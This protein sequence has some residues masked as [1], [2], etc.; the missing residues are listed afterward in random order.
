[1][2]YLKFLSL[3][4]FSFLIAT[5][6]FAQQTAIVKGKVVDK[7]KKPIELAT[8]SIQDL[9]KGVVTDAGGNYRMQVSSGRNITI[10][11]SFLGY[12]TERI[13]VNLKAGEEKT[14]NI[15]LI[16][17]STTIEGPVVED[18]QIRTSTLARID[19]K[20]AVSIPSI[21]GN[22][23]SLIKTMPGVASGNELSSQYSVR[24]GNFDENLVYVNDIEIYRPFLVRSG[25]QEGL[26]F[27][28]SDLVSS[29]LFSAGGFDA[30]YGDKM[31][32]VLD[33][34]Y[35]KPLQFAGSASASLL[36]ASAH[37]E[38][39]SNNSKITY[40][41]GVRYKSNQY[42]LKAM[43]TKGEYKPSFTDVQTYISW[44]PKPDIEVSF[45]GN[46]AL[47][48][49]KVVPQDRETAF[50]TIN[51]AYKFKVYFEGQEVDRFENY[52]SAMSFSWKPQ[53]NINLKLIGSAFSSAESETY[54]ILGQYWI[55]RLDSNIGS[56][57]YADIVEAVGV[58][59]YLNHARNFLDAN[60]Y[61]LE[62]RAS[63]ILNNSFWQWGVKYQHEF[64]DD[65]LNEWVLIDSAGYSLPHPIS[66]PGE[67]N[68]KHDFFLNTAIL[69]NNVLNSNRYSAFIQNTWT[70]DGDHDRIHLTTGVRTNYWDLNEQLLV[71]PRITL[72]Y[73]PV[74]QKDVLF[75]FSA[76]YYNQPPFYRELRNLKG[77]INRDLKAQTSIHF[78][79]AADY[80]FIAWNRPFKLIAE[81]YYKHL[82][83]LIP[84]EIDNVRIRYH[85]LN[86]AKGFAQGID[87]KI[88]GE[89]V[90]GIDSWVS[91][92][93]MKTMED[94]KDDF[95][96]NSEGKRIEPGYIPR[97]TDQRVNFSLFFQDYLPRNPTYKM[98]LNLLFGSGLTFGPPNSPRYKQTLRIP[99]YRR[100]DIGFSKEIIGD[101]SPLRERPVF[102]H[103]KSLWASLEVFNLLQ[104]N[105]T[106]SYI[107]ISDVRNRQY[108]IPN[109][110]TPRQLNIKLQA[111]F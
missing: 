14:I 36:G 26:S 72:S 92:S 40:L 52:M 46:Y 45:L 49:F 28:N 62:H 58:G 96:I 106:V 12:T 22:V 44:K 82:D 91:F 101:N 17:T 23:E 105:N 30:K 95:Y 4:F 21:S 71:S 81:A 3:I 57:E 67:I 33:I 94:I 64:I 77:E 13:T 86:N 79:A 48:N 50:G 63:C 47:N 73:N 65:Q 54:D 38:G 103:F 8:V 107:W 75:R 37:F 18:K 15:T 89:F 87:F 19:P 97:P 110:L 88:N 25:Q 61:S 16:E 9:N 90:K 31:A 1:M 111:T 68:E 70:L 20:V 51:E 99:P 53:S 56:N 60:V 78:V 39:I 34:Q 32:S 104:V 11:C 98:H 80:N 76:G 83:N 109:Y 41:A 43:E 85:A 74:W 10:V 35:K 7:N 42:V 102:R 5:S 24:G 6:A 55:G 108:A 100:V 27:L 29:I 93:V 2:R 59:S 69:T 66:I 84:Y